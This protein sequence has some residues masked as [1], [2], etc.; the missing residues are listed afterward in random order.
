MQKLAV[1]CV[2]ALFALLSSYAIV[3]AWPDGQA[4]AAQM[5]HHDSLAR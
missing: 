2:L 3:L 1:T 5:D 4:V